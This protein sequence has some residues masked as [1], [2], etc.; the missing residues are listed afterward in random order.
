MSNRA[1]V[2]NPGG[3]RPTGAAADEDAFVAGALE[4]T[5][6]AERN[7]NTLIAGVVI[8]VL[9][10][11]GGLYWRSARAAEMAAAV[12][13]LEGIAQ[14]MEFGDAT[15]ARGNLER[16]LERYGGSRYALEARLL[17]GQIHVQQGN[18][19]LAEEVLEPASRSMGDPVGLQAAFLLAVALENQERWADAEALYLEI[20]R[21]DA[22]DFQ[23][24]DA[25]GDAARLRAQQGNVQGAAE[26]YRE[27]LGLLEEGDPARGIFEMRLAEVTAGG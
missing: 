20:A 24:R 19:G 2:R 18:P 3:R 8:L 22:L 15:T 11:A 7:R 14:V 27:L 23:V 25:L 4:V 21:S 9:L 1:S 10:V 12:G 16:F 13:E 17:L 6:W 26:L 5:S